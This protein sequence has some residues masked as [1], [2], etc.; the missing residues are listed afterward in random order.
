M[1][2][3][4][5]LG[6]YGM[7]RTGE[8]LGIR[9]K[10]VIVDLRATTAVI[11]LGFTKGGK[12][13]GA[14]ES[15]T[16]AVTEIVRRL[17]QWKLSTSP[18]TLCPSPQSWRKAFSLGLTALS[19]ESWTVLLALRGGYLLGSGNMGLWTAFSCKEDGWLP[20]RQEPI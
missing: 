8:L 2:L 15:V 19:V 3:S 16:V 12:R 11:S 20:A 1:A 10:D 18:G 6:F 7:L 4:A 5:L 13:T 17:A 9:N 14:A